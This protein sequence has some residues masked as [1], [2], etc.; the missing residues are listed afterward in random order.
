M[1]QSVHPVIG[2]LCSDVV[3][4]TVHQF[5]PDQALLGGDGFAVP[6][7]EPGVELGDQC[8]VHRCLAVQPSRLGQCGTADQRGLH[9]SQLGQ[10]EL[11]VFDCGAADL[12][13]HL[14]RS[15]IVEQQ[16]EHPRLRLIGGVIALRDRAAPSRPTQA[17]R[18]V[19]VEA[20]LALVE[21]E[22]LPGPA[23][24]RVAGGHLEH[25][26]GRTRSL[27]VAQVYPVALAH[28]PGTDAF[29]GELADPAG[30]EGGG[31]PF[32]GQVVGA[33]NGDGGISHDSKVSAGALLVSE[34]PAQALR[35]CGCGSY[36]TCR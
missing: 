34:N 4:E 29:D 5:L 35:R 2:A 16:G 25:H 13:A 12:V 26:R 24:H 20:D 7:D 31:Q 33:L 22:G 36:S 14:S 19:E 8:L 30:P 18:D 23:A 15:S 17:R 27:V 3:V 32:G 9:L 6:V 1:H 21:A 11:G 10:C 28:L